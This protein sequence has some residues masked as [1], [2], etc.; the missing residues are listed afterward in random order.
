MFPRRKHPAFA[1]YLALCVA[2]LLIGTLL[3][4]LSSSQITL[5]QSQPEAL[6]SLSGRVTDDQGNPLEGITVSLELYPSDSIQTL[7]RTTSDATGNYSFPS[8]Y[9][10]SYAIRFVDPTGILAESYYKKGA[11]YEEATIVMVSGNAVENIDMQMAMGGAITV[12]LENTDAFTISLF[13]GMLYRKSPLGRWANYRSIEIE[14]SK[15]NTLALTGLPFGVYRICGMLSAPTIIGLSICYNFTQ[16]DRATSLH[17]ATDIVIDSTTP[18]QITLDPFAHSQLHGSVVSF[19]GEPLPDVRIFAIGATADAMALTDEQGF[20]RFQYLPTGP[21]YLLAYE[22][23][24]EDGKRPSGNRLPTIYPNTLN[25][26][27]AQTVDFDSSKGLSITFEMVEGGMITGIVKLPD[28]I[29]LTDPRIELYQRDMSNGNLDLCYA[30]NICRSPIYEPSTGLYTFTHLTPGQYNLLVSQ[31]VPGRVYEMIN[32]YGAD[33]PPYIAQP[34]TVI[35]GQTT[36]NINVTFGEKS[37]DGGITGTVTL[38]GVGQPDLV[39]G[40]HSASRANALDHPF[41]TTTTDANGNYHL[42]NLPIGYYRVSVRDPQ[43]RYVYRFYQTASTASGESSQIS[44]NGTAT[45]PNV[46]IELTTA[47]TIRGR[48]VT[49]IHESPAGYRILA[50]RK[51]PYILI[52]PGTIVGTISNADGTY[53]LTGL[54]PDTPYIINATPPQNSYYS[55]QDI[56]YYPSS[57]N[58]Y[59]ALTAT[60]QA[61]QVTP[62]INII[63]E[64]P[65]TTLLPIIS[66]E[67]AVLR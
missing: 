39:I 50:A 45:T 17:T 19:K 1:L 58:I 27:E 49:P 54:A 11:T 24:I 44:V 47:G 4:L 66:A 41:L 59:T 64:Y 33:I 12:T 14:S 5:A 55:S 37:F 32:Y 16:N 23:A 43:G 18:R 38:D 53:E 61:G 9:P 8:L 29:P 51:T 30:L 35:T 63:Y 21:Y 67:S 25:F 6:G 46:N 15:G 62:N 56:R 13:S 34:I 52:A 60:V 65:Q 22:R 2:C 10:G 42:A 7:R 48:I 31:N 20:F 3:F 28:N 57:E 36:A 40:L 26:G